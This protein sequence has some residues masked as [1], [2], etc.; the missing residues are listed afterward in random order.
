[1]K[2]MDEGFESDNFTNNSHNDIPVFPS[3][4]LSVL[5][6]S[7]RKQTDIR[8]VVVNNKVWRMGINSPLNNAPSS[9][10]D[11]THVRVLLGVLTFWKGDNPLSM[12]IKELARR[13]SGSHGGAYF[14]LLRQKLGDLRDYWIEVELKDGMKRIFPALSRIEISTHNTLSN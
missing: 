2:L 13:C 1:M 8:E 10:I 11:M 3:D 9:K 4:W 12:S 7:P 14:K 6:F 5:E